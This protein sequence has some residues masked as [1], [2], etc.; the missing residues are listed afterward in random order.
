MTTAEVLEIEFESIKVDLIKKY[1]ELNLR[2]SGD[3]AN[4]LES[5]INEKDH[6]TNIKLYGNNYTE[7]LI[8]GRE[9]GKFPPIKSIEKWI[10]DK[11][12][13]AIGKEISISSLA[14]LIA[15][16]IANE[17]TKIYQKGGTDLVS[18]VITPQR[19]QS[20]INRV[21]EINLDVIVKG[22]TQ[23]LKEVA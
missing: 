13:R 6:I 1:D 17:G 21:S 15:R 5:V 16:K 20:I 19:I 8:K 18:S 3:W 9:P 23:Q 7:Q 11:G 12:I 22:I 4:S 10:Y 14:F 2:A